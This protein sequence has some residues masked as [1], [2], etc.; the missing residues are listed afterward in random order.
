M[1]RKKASYYKRLEVA[2]KGTQSFVDTC[3]RRRDIEVGQPPVGVGE[4]VEVD[5]SKTPAE[6][7]KST[8][9]KQK[10]S[11]NVDV[12]LCMRILSIIYSQVTDE[13]IGSPCL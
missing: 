1:P 6:K 7:R 4:C 11:V 8:F 12:S 3:K 2:A 13:E 5:R 9:E 10:M